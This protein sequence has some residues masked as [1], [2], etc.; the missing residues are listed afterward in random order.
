MPALSR[1]C[2]VPVEVKGG[3]KE[4]SD[5]CVLYVYVVK[6]ICFLCSSVVKNNHT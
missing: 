5:L 6:K 3:K 4:R 2:T 1:A